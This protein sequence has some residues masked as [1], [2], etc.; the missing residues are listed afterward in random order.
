MELEINSSTTEPPSL[1]SYSLKDINDKTKK[2]ID[3]YYPGINLRDWNDWKWQLTNS[4]DSVESLSRIFKISN[5][6]LDFDKKSR[7]PIRITPYYASLI[8]AD[9]ANDPLGL[10][11]LPS[12]KELILS[13]H[14]AADP[15]CEETQTKT[16]GLVHRYP[17]R[18]LFLVTAFCAT[19][20]RYC[21]RSR[22]VG[23]VET[24]RKLRLNWEKA[25]QYIADHKEIRD[26]LISGGDPLQLSN[27]NI[28]Y[29][30]SRIRAIPHVEIIRIGTKVPVVLPQKIE[31]S[32][33]RILKKYHPLLI[34][35]H[36]THPNELTP[37]TVSACKK[38]SEAGILLG[39]QTVLLKNINDNVDT[40]KKLFHGLLKSRVRPYYLYQCDPAFGTGHFRTP[41]EKGV[42]IIN[43]LR[44][45][46]SGLAIPFFIVDAPGGGGKIHIQPNTYLGLKEGVHLLKNFE[47]KTF[48]YPEVKE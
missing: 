13:V 3:K 35:I 16:K 29:L 14:E 43:E 18:V 9:D 42:E 21:T 2:F 26:V 27:A 24:S 36:F 25:I 48:K 46:T 20:C 31:P 15:L 33:I 4:F 40:L 41:L 28:E 12:N 45:N 10:S 19:Y 11:V 5:D 38:L 30:L 8:D 1:C 6:L 7:L 22:M 44:G 32:L 23:E 17:D 47:G 34:N 37:E 39:S